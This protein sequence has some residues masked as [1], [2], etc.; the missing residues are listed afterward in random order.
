[1]KTYNSIPK[2]KLDH[3]GKSIFS[4]EKIDGSNFR[5]EWDLN[6]SKKN[7]SSYGFEKFGTRSELILNSTNP[8]HEGVEIFQKE[9]SS[10]L[11]KIFREEKVFRG[12]KRI[13]AY[14]EFYGY[15]SFA[16]QH[17]WFDD[18]YLR[19]FDIFIYKK[20]FLNPSDFLKI[21][22]GKLKIQRL[23]YNGLLT[24]EYIESVEHGTGEGVVYKGIEEKKIFMGKIKTHEWLNKVKDLYGNTKMLEY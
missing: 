8:F 22:E 12:V 1:M 23:V 4:F 2:Y 18:H 9:Y 14:L 6:I 19:L 13:T 3:I 20:D 17:S 16:G 21:F 15:G 7:K 5:A 10:Q 24:P 11:D